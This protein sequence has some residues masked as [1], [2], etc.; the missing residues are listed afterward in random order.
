[1]E[2]KSDDQFLAVPQDELGKGSLLF[3]P[4][5]PHLNSGRAALGNGVSFYL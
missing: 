5:V 2:R 1:M 3:K 4:Q